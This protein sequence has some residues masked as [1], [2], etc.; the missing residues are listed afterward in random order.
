MANWVS[1]WLEVE[2]IG[3]DF[4]E[5]KIDT[6]DFYN[7]MHV[8]SDGP[9][10]L[11]LDSKW[12]VPLAALSQISKE[13]CAGKDV[14]LTYSSCQNNPQLESQMM[15]HDGQITGVRERYND[16]FDADDWGAFTLVDAKDSQEMLDKA[17]Q[18]DRREQRSRQ[19]AALA[20][21]IE[22][23]TPGCD[24]ELDQE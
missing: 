17:V 23:E 24:L 4:D 18:M 20:A 5:G 13:S 14:L 16:G 11:V 19:A 22:T 15:L 1:N 2:G 21:D 3:R 6:K 7:V 9:D 8:Q 10:C 12:R